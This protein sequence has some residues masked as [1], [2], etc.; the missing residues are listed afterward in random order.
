MAIQTE[1]KTSPGPAEEQSKAS[2]FDEYLEGRIS[3]VEVF[4]TILADQLSISFDLIARTNP[5]DE[6]SMRNLFLKN[7]AVS[8]DGAVSRMK[9]ES[10]ENEYNRGYSDGIKLISDSLHKRTNPKMQVEE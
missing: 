9:E 2:K 3:A 10:N 8:L 5:E 7:L 6:S 4:C 1:F